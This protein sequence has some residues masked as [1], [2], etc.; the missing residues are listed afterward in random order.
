MKYYI[1]KITSDDYG[2]CN[3]LDVVHLTNGMVIT[4]GHEGICLDKSE[5]S[6]NEGEEPINC[7]SYPE[8]V[9][10]MTAKQPF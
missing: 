1:E 5:E 3:Y 8:E 7:I 6:F 9:K 4:I 10:V 2:H